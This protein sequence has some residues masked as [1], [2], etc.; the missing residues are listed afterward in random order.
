[1]R[2][3]A[4]ALLALTLIAAACSDDSEEAEPS[5]CSALQDLSS[6]VQSLVSLDVLSEGT[7]GLQSSLDDVESSFEQVKEDSGDQ[8][9]SEVDDLQKAIDDGLDTLKSLPDSDSVGDA[10]DSVN[11]AFTNIQTAY[12]ALVTK[13]EGELSDCDLSTSS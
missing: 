11:E 13:A 12:D 4:V 5:T 9:G 2:R 10:A 6:S 3:L 7:S 1:M 8:F